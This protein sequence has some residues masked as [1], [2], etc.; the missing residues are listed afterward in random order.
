ML[1]IS[2]IDRGKLS[3]QTEARDL[4]ELV[5]A[6]VDR[7]SPQRVQAETP[8]KLTAP[9]SVL[10]EWERFKLEQVIINLLTN[11]ARNGE[12]QPIEVTALRR[13]YSVVTWISCAVS[14]DTL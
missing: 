4:A 2:Q 12:R 1:D 10:G 13:S 14:H 7:L 8:V 9:E 6:V 5:A 3:L 11:A